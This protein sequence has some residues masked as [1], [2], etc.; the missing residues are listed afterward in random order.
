MSLPLRK[1]LIVL[2]CLMAPL[3]NGPV[4]AHG[5]TLIVHHF[6]PD[7]SPFHSEFLIPWSQKLEKQSAGLLRFRF[8][9]GSDINKL[10]DDVADRTSDIAFTLTRFTPTRFPAMEAFERTNVR[11]SAQGASRAAW[12][13]FRM[14]EL[15]DKDFD[16]MRLLAV[17]VTPNSNGTQDVGLLVMNAR[18]YKAL[19]ETLRKVVNDNSGSEQSAALAAAMTGDRSAPGP[20]GK[21]NLDTWITEAGQRGLDAKAL[22]DSARALLGQYDTPKN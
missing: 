7:N 22:A 2:L 11:H 20:A 16:E 3:A 14:N 9:P 18:S 12:E 4:Q 13:Y 5:V 17:A 15:A 21:D 10:A 19:T 8:V 1:V 6:L